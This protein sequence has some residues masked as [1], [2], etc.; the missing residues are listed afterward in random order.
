MARQLGQDLAAELLRS[1]AGDL[2]RVNGDR[3][4]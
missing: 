4:R 2:L 1:G 3:L